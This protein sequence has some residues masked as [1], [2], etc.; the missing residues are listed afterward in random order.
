MNS[1]LTIHVASDFH[2]AGPAERKRRDFESQGIANPLWRF[3]A[4]FY[5]RFIWLADPLAHHAQLDRFLAAAGPADLVVA[6]GDYSCDSA[7]VGVSDAA[8]RESAA[9]CLGKLRARFGA[10]LLATIGDH[11]LGKLSLFGG[12]GG[13]RLE[14]W[15]C[16]TGNLGLAPFWEARRGR[17]VL[18][19]VTS[20][21]IALPVYAREALPAERPAWQQLREDHLAAIRAA[22]T[23]LREE[24]RV[25]LFCHDPTALPFLLE[26]EAVCRRLDQVL[27][28]VIG[29]L[30]SEAVMKA[31][32]LLAG[33]P[34]INFLGNT[35][36]RLSTALRQARAWP[37]F[38]ARLCPSPSGIQLLKDGGF[39]T[40]TLPE[41]KERPLR[42]E[43]TRL[44]WT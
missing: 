42:V 44:P 41:E 34:V 36:R 14:S 2:Y 15:H 6:N 32:R 37:R 28:T 21:L 26:E 22:F 1:G 4:R 10:G 30:H 40:L 23:R 35:P 17:I 11:E 9:E 18:M 12:V 27:L 7:F 20:T 39:L 19:G 31:S 38:K 3:L 16:A 8:A 13:L 33:M 25:L 29:H 43:F 5:R 24:D